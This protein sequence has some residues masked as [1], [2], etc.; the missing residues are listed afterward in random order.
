M[1]RFATSSL[2]SRTRQAQ[3]ILLPP[4]TTAESP[5]GCCQETPL[6]KPGPPRCHQTLLHTPGRS[7]AAYNRG[8]GRECRRGP[9]PRLTARASVTSEPVTSAL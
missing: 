9:G 7:A 3:L 4:G 5:V 2:R 6:R 1:S 8:G